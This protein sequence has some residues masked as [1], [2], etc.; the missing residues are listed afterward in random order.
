MYVGHLFIYVLQTEIFCCFLGTYASS[1]GS[2]GCT[3]CTAG[4]YCDAVSQTQCGA[5]YY[6]SAGSSFCT[7]CPVGHKCPGNNET[8]PTPCDA[9]E[10]QVRAHF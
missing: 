6:S 8:E 9:G 2:S 4:F 5:G 7:P 1:Q 10:Y 3:V